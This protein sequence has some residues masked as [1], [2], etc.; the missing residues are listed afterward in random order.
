MGTRFV[1]VG[2]IKYGVRVGAVS[3]PPPGA[4]Y[5][6]TA[7]AVAAS[8]TM[9]GV[10]VLHQHHYHHLYE[11]CTATPTP[12]QTDKECCC[13]VVNLPWT[14]S[15][16]S[17]SRIPL[18]ED[19]QQLS[20]NSCGIFSSVN[21]A[22]IA[23]GYA[24]CSSLPFA[25]RECKQRIKSQLDDTTYSETATASVSTL[26]TTADT[27]APTFAATEVVSGYDRNSVYRLRS[28][29]SHPPQLGLRSCVAA[30][31][32][33]R[34]SSSTATQLFLRRHRALVRSRSDAEANI[35]IHVDTDET[36]ALPNELDTRQDTLDRLHRFRFGG[37][38]GNVRGKKFRSEDKS[39]RFREL[40]D[41][42]K[43][44]T[45]LP[46]LS[47]SVPPSQKNAIHQSQQY[48]H[49]TP[50]QYQKLT[51]SSNHPSHSTTIR[52]ANMSTNGSQVDTVG[53]V[54]PPRT[55]HSV[56]SNSS[57]ISTPIVTSSPSAGSS[58]HLPSPSQ[59]RINMH[60]KPPFESNVLLSE[61]LTKVDSNTKRTV[62][63]RSAS[64]SLVDFSAD[65]KYIRNRT[66]ASDIKENSNVYRSDLSSRGAVTLPRKKEN[67]L[68]HLHVSSPISKI[69]YSDLDTETNLEKL[70]E[71]LS[72][73]NVSDN[74]E[75]S[76]SDQSQKHTTTD[77]IEASKQKLR[78]SD[79]SA[80]SSVS[81]ASE[82]ASTEEKKR[83][84]SRRRKGMYISQWPDQ[85]AS[86][87]LAYAQE[88][89]ASSVGETV[90]SLKPRSDECYV[91]TLSNSMYEAVSS[92][93]IVKNQTQ[94]T[95]EEA[96][97]ETIDPAIFKR[98]D[99]FS[100][101]E[102]DPTERRPLTPVPSLNLKQDDLLSPILSSFDMSDFE[103]KSS[104][105]NDSLSPET[106]RR[107]S[108]RPLR[109]PY[110][111]MLEAEMKR[112]DTNKT[113]SKQNYSNAL[114]FLDD[115]ANT[116]TS[117]SNVASSMI[118]LVSENPSNTKVKGRLRG[119]TNHSLD[120]SNLKSSH[121]PETSVF[122]IPS[123]NCKTGGDILL[124][125]PTSIPGFEDLEPGQ[126]SIFSCH[127]RTT[128]SPS[129]LE[130]NTF[131]NC[132]D[133][134]ASAEPSTDFLCDLVRTSS[135]Q[136]SIPAATD[137]SLFTLLLVN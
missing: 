26:M 103:N 72:Q 114:K 124:S 96:K 65:G 50:L 1:T 15:V 22:D 109:G 137:V 69:E 83:D 85:R 118:S 38:R 46:P 136:I 9:P 2:S 13:N 78:I 49:V 56:G 67:Q 127:Q 66:S 7:A 14:R 62:P 74:S 75:F 97:S 120:D 52:E 4:R 101:G 84:R 24:S 87:M 110:G 57:R 77:N 100:E 70:C 81:S 28:S 131:P 16:A 41:R 130:A 122:N 90:T 35:H 71:R 48:S 93:H 39:E 12:M 119:I 106:P 42:L 80:G 133:R 86:V 53:P 45:H 135:E 3:P 37:N 76:K 61:S 55:R 121:M 89:I 43:S 8:E 68:R 112:P 58:S 59:S 21:S 6:S 79:A 117:T 134:A 31:E 5:R 34:F 99:S 63:L 36:I 17:V 94:P 129:N 44:A 51:S 126:R 29:W 107:Y 19:K 108:K 18:L 128:S 98:I 10:G 111:Q 32:Q 64:F 132:S 23:N 123:P 91:N 102:N 73:E 115:L 82:S 33:V 20:I 125:A 54:P 88:E 47:T 11:T 113:F 105:C 30:T 60:N 27:S 95:E 116:N 25:E 40:T 104:G 92:E